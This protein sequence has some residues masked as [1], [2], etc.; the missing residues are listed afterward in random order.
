MTTKKQLWVPPCQPSRCFLGE[1]RRIYKVPS[2]SCSLQTSAQ[3]TLE[4]TAEGWFS[5][6]P[7]PSLWFLKS[8][9][10]LTQ[11]HQIIHSLPKPE[12]PSGSGPQA[13]GWLLGGH[14]SPHLEEPPSGGRWGKAAVC[15]AQRWYSPADVV[16]AVG[17]DAR[18]RCPSRTG[19]EG[20]GDPLSPHAGEFLGTGRGCLSSCG[21]RGPCLGSQHSRGRS[22][23]LCRTWLSAERCKISPRSSF[24]MLQILDSLTFPGVELIVEPGK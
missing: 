1:E 9:F 20:S 6:Y 19:G 4:R 7:P 10:R 13:P 5:L 18:R 3:E 24:D 21:H 22:T 16:L 17:E 8:V 15:G 2:T 11:L 12:G 23:Q 14:H